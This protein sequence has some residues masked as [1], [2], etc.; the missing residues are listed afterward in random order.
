M[1]VC[2]CVLRES[3]PN[4]LT[5]STSA[6][7]SPAATH[8]LGPDDKPHRSGPKHGQVWGA[9]DTDFFPIAEVKH[10][11]IAE[12]SNKLPVQYWEVHS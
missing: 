6:V 3:G 11:G 10:A 5:P 4:F 8:I 12:K 9:G 7:I 2:V 1:H